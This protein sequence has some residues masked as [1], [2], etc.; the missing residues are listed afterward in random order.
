[1]PNSFFEVEHSTDIQ[2]SLEKFNDLRDFYAKM[3]IVADEKRFAEYE[4]KMNYTSFSVMKKEKRVSF[5]NY[6]DLE[7]Q[8][9]QVIEQQSMQTIIL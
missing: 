8:Y 4:K 6:H 7:K 2:N 3:Y 9:N 1:M 5:L